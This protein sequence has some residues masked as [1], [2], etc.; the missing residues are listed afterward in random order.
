MAVITICA[1]CMILTRFDALR[2]EY[3]VQVGSAVGLGT[4]PVLH[5][6]EH[7][8]VDLAARISSNRMVEDAHDVV[9]DLVHGDIWMFPGV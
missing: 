2:P 1:S 8:F 3:V 7:G 9:E 5:N 4:R 6:V